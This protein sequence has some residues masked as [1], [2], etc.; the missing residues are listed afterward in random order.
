MTEIRP[1]L[2][3]KNI[4]TIEKH[5]YYEL[6][7]FC[8][9]YPIWKKAEQS[10]QAI[11]ESEIRMI[12][13]QMSDHTNLLERCRRQSEPYINRMRLIERC[14]EEAD[15]KAKD[16]LL[17]GVT[18]GLTYDKLSARY[19]VCVSRDRYYLDYRRFFYILSHSQ[20]LHFL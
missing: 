5:R 3:D 8:L 9:Q 4:Y 15:P 18:E 6:K 16:I 17:I 11:A 1:K 7:H 12:K 13:V 19:D 10:I 20:I 2:S 14:C